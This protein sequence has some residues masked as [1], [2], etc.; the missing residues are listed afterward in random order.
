[1]LSCS[2]DPRM[3]ALKFI[4]YNHPCCL[5]HFKQFDDRASPC[6]ALNVICRDCH[7][8]CASPVHSS[9]VGCWFVHDR[10]KKLANVS[11]SEIN[12]MGNAYLSFVSSR[13]ARGQDTTLDA[14]SGK[15]VQYSMVGHD[16]DT[17]IVF[18]GRLAV[19]NAFAHEHGQA[20]GLWQL[21]DDA[22]D[23]LTPPARLPRQMRILHLPWPTPI[24]ANRPLPSLT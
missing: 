17:G 6:F 10:G 19:E 4:I 16:E 9:S 24:P 23:T 3:R 12:L 1:M 13:A 8:Q 5:S 15:M 18:V 22:V 2:S 21:R 11:T 20:R 14:A 7:L